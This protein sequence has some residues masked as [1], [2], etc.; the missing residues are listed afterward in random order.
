MGTPRGQIR[1]FRPKMTPNID[2]LPPRCP[3]MGSLLTF[4]QLI[5]KKYLQGLSSRYFCGYFVLSNSPNW[6]NF[7]I[8]ST[9]VVI[10]GQNLCII[11]PRVP[12]YR[13]PPNFYAIDI[14]DIA[15]RFNRNV[16]LQLLCVI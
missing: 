12:I 8:I 3:Y 2:I 5:L 14:E 11:H 13:V 15:S 7:N 1:K 16:F 10:F 4:M 9:F 6:K